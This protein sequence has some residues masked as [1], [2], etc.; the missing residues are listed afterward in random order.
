MKQKLIYPGS[1]DPITL[2]HEDIIK[3]A[4]NSFPKSIIYVVIANNRDKKHMFNIDERKTMVKK[5]IKSLNIT[6]VKVVE[7]EGIISDFINENNINSVIRGLRNYTD[8]EYEKN[9]ETFTRETTWAET[10][11]LSTDTVHA[12]TSSSLVRTFIKTE[13]SKHIKAMVSKKVFKYII[14]RL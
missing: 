6:N 2:G 10:I 1:F 9:I 14:K 7:F 11:Y 13:H 8:F 12:S 3:R 4:S 5:A